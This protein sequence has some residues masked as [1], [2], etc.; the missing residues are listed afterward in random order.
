LSVFIYFIILFSTYQTPE[1]ISDME[2]RASA[3]TGEASAK[4]INTLPIFGGKCTLV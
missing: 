3:Y 4:A 1:N 2:A